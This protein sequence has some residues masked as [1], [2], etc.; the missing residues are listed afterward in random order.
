[1]KLHGMAHF[2]SLLDDDFKVCVEHFWKSPCHVC[3]SALGGV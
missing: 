3:C 1:V 2:D